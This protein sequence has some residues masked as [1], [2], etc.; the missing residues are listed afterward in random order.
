MYIF[1]S[2]TSSLPSW[3]L[4]SPSH[5]FKLRHGC[6]YIVVTSTLELLS[7][8][9]NTVYIP[10]ACTACRHFT[11]V[12][13]YLP[14]LDVPLSCGCN[15]PGQLRAAGRSGC[16]LTFGASW[17]LL[18]SA[19]RLVSHCKVP[20]MPPVVHDFYSSP[21][22]PLCWNGKAK[23]CTGLGYQ[24]LSPLRTPL[25]ISFAC[26]VHRPFTTL[27]QPTYKPNVEHSI[28]A[29]MTCSGGVKTK[30]SPFLDL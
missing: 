14:S 6:N 4:S 5:S 17:W 18:P 10:A 3:P 21:E 28:V 11:A 13:H 29:F 26:L 8:H 9:A 30:I 24:L 27:H 23:R 7:L 25:Y 20:A 19:R 15:Q 16:Q 12:R 1:L 2:C 22:N